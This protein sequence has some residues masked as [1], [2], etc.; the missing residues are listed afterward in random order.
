MEREDQQITLELFEKDLENQIAIYLS[1][2]TF[3]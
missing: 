3:N 1:K 2:I